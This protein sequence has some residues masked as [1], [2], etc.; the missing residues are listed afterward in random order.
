MGSGSRFVRARQK[1]TTIGTTALLALGGVGCG[2]S[3][4]STP[5][6]SSATAIVDA[7]TSSQ[8]PAREPPM[9]KENAAEVTK[10][11]GPY[12]V[13]LPN[14]ARLTLYTW[15]KPDQIEALAKDPTLLTRG[16]SPEFGT[17]FFEQV[18]EQRAQTKDSLAQLLRTA[19]F[20]KQRYAWVAP[21]A[22]RIGLGNE[23]YGDELIQVVL[24][25][26]SWFV[27]MKMSSPELLVVDANN[28]PVNKADVLAHP[29]RLAAA[30]FAQDKPVTGYRASM[31]GPDERIG[32]REYVLFNESMIASYSVGTPAIAAEL[33]TETRAVESLLRYVKTNET[34]VDYFN[35]WVVDIATTTWASPPD[36]QS[37]LKTFE[38]SLAFADYPYMP[39][40]R[41][42]TSLVENLRK[43]KL[44]DKPF[45]HTPTIKF[46]AA[47]TKT[48]APTPRVPKK[49][50]GT[51]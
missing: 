25:P 51:F 38:S 19:A 16:E 39:A 31:A 1:T 14:I 35:K 6:A 22:T 15:T 30:Y 3:T 43:L 50:N 32:Y 47:G 10:Q 41:N 36:L 29:E 40:E 24:K 48:P 44:R 21:F 49:T 20:A 37:P 8:A 27:I 42:L 17:S 4:T 28:Q 33:E 46:P 5:T 11:L 45:T 18:L 23:S 2:R 7:F 9:A 34:H 12:T 13:A 26:E